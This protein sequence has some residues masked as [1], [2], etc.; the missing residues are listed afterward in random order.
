MLTPEEAAL[1]AADR[2]EMAVL[3]A[4]AAKEAE[5][6]AE[7]EAAEA[8]KAEEKAAAKAAK[9]EAAAQKKAEE[10]AA[11]Q[12][13]AAATKTKKAKHAK[14][15]DE[16]DEEVEEAAAASEGAE[17]DV[18]P[19]EI[20]ERFFVPASLWPEEKPKKTPHGKGWL[21]TVVAIA[22][23]EKAGELS[24]PS[25]PC[26]ALLTSPHLGAAPASPGRLGDTWHALLTP[27]PLVTRGMPSSPHRPW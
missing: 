15:D 14:E 10:A 11:K 2:E 18:A 17:G 26:L 22:P 5:D 19:P 16:E 7:L 21:A 24:L 27:P 23:S 4:A 1:E 25:A 12:A 20:D 6:A 13:A 3:E 8:A 9:A